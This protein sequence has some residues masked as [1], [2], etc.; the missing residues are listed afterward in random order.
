MIGFVL[1]KTLYDYWDNM[2]RMILL[3]LGFLLVVAIPIFLPSLVSRFTDSIAV[4]MALTGFGILIC[5]I[6]LATAAFSIKSI[7]DYGSFGFGNFFRNIKK[8]WLSGLVMGLFVFLLFLVITVIIPF[9]LSMASILGL[10]L[11]AVVF[12]VTIFALVSFQFYYFV[13]AR[14]G[15][16][17]FKSFKK[18]MILSMDNTG[19]SFFLFIHNLIV[20]LLPFTITFTMFLIILPGTA[21]ILLYIDEALRLRLYKYDWIEA[22]PN[23]NRKKIPWEELLIEDREKI[24]VRSFRNFVFPWKD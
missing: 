1:R 14:L 19:F 7:S 22:N 17:I 24:G 21:G 5:S 12:W 6:Y 16:K 2:F 8:A 3:N 13:Y 15:G 20:I 18:C 11:A 4:Q 10:L 23:A 9:Y